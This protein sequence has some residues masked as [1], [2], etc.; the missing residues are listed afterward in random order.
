MR[1]LALWLA[2][3]PAYF[4]SGWGAVASLLL[5]MAAW[6]AL[7][8]HFGPLVLPTPHETAQAAQALLQ[9]AGQG[10]DWLRQLGITARRAFAGLGLA[11]LLGSVAGVLLGS[12]LTA[13]MMARP[14]VTVLMGT[15]P[16]AWLVMA[17]LWFG[18]GDGTP[19]FTV[20][21]ACFPVVLV[22]GMQ[23][24][25]T[26]DGR[27]RELARS[28]GLPWWMRLTDVNLPHILS[29]LF[30]AWTVA[31]GSAWRVV[32][33]AELL[34]SSDGVGAALAASRSQLDMATSLVWIGLVVGLLLLMEYAVLEPI[35]RELER[36]RRQD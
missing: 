4:W 30:P 2:R 11:L 22:A 5:L 17:M 18:T 14:W 9:G 32:V 21:V 12:S 25:R 28:L 26:L 10:G 3:L 6:D 36:W 31:L 23:G 13:S 1:L 27:W 15:P 35:K 8:R 29:Y 19:L 33:M 20:F 16:I 7:A 24:A 34:A